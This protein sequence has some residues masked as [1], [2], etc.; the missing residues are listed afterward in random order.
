MIK[1]DI[2]NSSAEGFLLSVTLIGFGKLTESITD[3]EVGE[4]LRNTAYALSILVAV[5]TLL[6]GKIKKAIAKLW[7]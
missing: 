4:V 1:M 6:G 7:K 3:I 5:D 2:D